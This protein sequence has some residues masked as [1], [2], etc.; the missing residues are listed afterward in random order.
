MTDY[1]VDFDGEYCLI[2]LRETSKYHTNIRKG[3]LYSEAY[4]LASDLNTVISLFDKKYETQ[5]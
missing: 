3:L 2:T 1:N 4:N 5:P